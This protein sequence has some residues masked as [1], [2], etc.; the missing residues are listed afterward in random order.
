MNLGCWGSGKGKGKG[1]VHVDFFSSLFQ[2]S[3]KVGLNQNKLTTVCI[4]F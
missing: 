2:K 4:T 1:S 3:G